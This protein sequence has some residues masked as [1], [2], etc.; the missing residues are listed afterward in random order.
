MHGARRITLHSLAKDQFILFPR[1]LAPSLYD[2]VISIYLEA[3]FSPH[4]ALEAQM[5]AIVSVVAA[6]IGVALVPSSL[7][8]LRR[9]G[10]I[11]KSLPSSV[12]KVEL[13]VA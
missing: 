3:G 12:P 4:I 7:Q 1:D 6:G 8:N 2:Q 5:Q 10:L 9:K 11:Y 13:A